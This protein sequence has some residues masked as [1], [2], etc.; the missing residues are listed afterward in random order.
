MINYICELCCYKT[1]DKSNYKKHVK[2]AKHQ[3]II[4]LNENT[5]H[6]IISKPKTNMHDDALF[7]ETLSTQLNE[8][9]KQLNTYVKYVENNN[10]IEAVE[11]ENILQTEEKELSSLLSTFYKEFP[12]EK[13]NLDEFLL[14][15]K[16]QNLDLLSKRIQKMN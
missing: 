6:H 5:Q 10:Q 3:R 9:Y 12:E 8:V 4:K 2:G 11:R 13:I 7:Y 1:T 14:T 16:K 15:K